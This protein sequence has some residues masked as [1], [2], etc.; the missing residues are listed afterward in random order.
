MEFIGV[1]SGADFIAPMAGRRRLESYF[2]EL[3]DA[4]TVG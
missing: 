3:A 4:G 2:Q 1:L